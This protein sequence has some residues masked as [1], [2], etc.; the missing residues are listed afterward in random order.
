MGVSKVE[1]EVHVCAKGRANNK[2]ACFTPV[3]ILT[4]NHHNCLPP[5]S[6]GLFPIHCV[7]W[8]LR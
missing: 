6:A 1:T 8:L 4:P 2:T 7:K 3:I 5:A